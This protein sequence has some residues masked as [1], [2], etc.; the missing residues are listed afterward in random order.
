MLKNCDARFSFDAPQGWAEVTF[1]AAAG[2][3]SLES[4]CLGHTVPFAD[5][6]FWIQPFAKV[7]VQ[8]DQMR[9]IGRIGNV[10][11]RCITRAQQ[12]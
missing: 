6:Q 12:Q 2:K 4:K 9:S 7:I 5:I 1:V 8:T 11:F 10:S 3:S